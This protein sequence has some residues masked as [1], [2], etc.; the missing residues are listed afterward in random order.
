MRKTGYDF[1]VIGA[2]SAG[3]VVANRLSEDGRHTVLLVE[4]GPRDGSIMLR[5]PAALGLPLQGKRY[6]WGY[7]GEPEPCLNGQRSSQP[8]GRVL[9]GTSSINGMVFVRGNALDFDGWR[10]SGLSNWSYEACLPYFRKMETFSGGPSPY[11][12]AHGPL[13]VR[14]CN[15]EGALYQAFL[16]AGEEYG[17]GFTDDPNGCRQEGVNVAQATIHHGERWSAARAYL[18]CAWQLG[19]LRIVT[20]GAVS[21][22]IM[23]GRKAVG[24]TFEAQGEVITAAA[25][26]EVI[27]CAGAFGSPQLLMLSG[28]GDAVELA[29]H[30]ISSSVHLPGVGKDL[31]DHVSVA[32]Q[33]T[34]KKRASPTRQLSQLGRLTVAGRWALT[35]GGLGASNYFEVGCF[36]KA[37][38]GMAQPNI[39]HEFFPMI[40]EFYRGRAKV[41]DGFQYFTSL[42][43]PQSR[44]S[45]TLASADPK[46]APAIRMNFLTHA[47][48][49]IHLREGVRKTRDII[50]Q[51][52]WG[53]LRD[54]EVTP[55][56]DLKS[57]A[58]LEEWIRRSAGSNYHATSTCRMGYDDLA[59][60]DAEGKVHGAENL[61]VVDASIMP[62]ITSGNTNAPTIMLAEKISDLILGRELAGLVIPFYH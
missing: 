41:Q 42:L 54:V 36:M 25:N 15:A 60:T 37:H 4:A 21:K 59:V 33:Y 8:R 5:M 17:L 13:H 2:G 57:D 32:I 14:R 44:G 47:E 6:N 29:R 50:A 55:G 12:G 35:R 45:V 39:Q 48:D 40:G 18:D 10:S 46:A 62:R 19:N 43:N 26:R 23:D 7:T 58:E 61:R 52:A 56:I 20:G 51:P 31:Q 28:I 11:R 9:G 27:L 3:C 34:S 22:I 53:P 1:I 24:V 38:D 16:R 49:L 30:G